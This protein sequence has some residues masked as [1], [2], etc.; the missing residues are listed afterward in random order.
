MELQE[1][2]PFYAAVGQGELFRQETPLEQDR[3]LM[4]SYFPENSDYVR[5]VVEDVMDRLDYE[6]SF[7]YDE[8]PDKWTIE[9]VCRDICGRIEA[10]LDEEQNTETEILEMRERRKS[11]RRDRRDRG[12]LEELVNALFCDEMHNRRCRR[13][14]IRRFF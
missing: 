6:G 14:R 8:I 13:R 3:R 11:R 12:L 7:I 1:I 4:H 9:R 10:E 5:A 2:K